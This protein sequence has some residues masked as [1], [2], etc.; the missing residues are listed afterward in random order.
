MTPGKVHSTMVALQAIADD[1][2][3]F[4]PGVIRAAADNA[5]ELLR[6]ARASYADAQMWRMGRTHGL[7]SDDAAQ[8]IS[9]AW[10]NAPEDCEPHAKCNGFMPGADPGRCLH[11]GIKV[12]AHQRRGGN[13]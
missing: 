5:L 7:I 12:E 6:E 1:P 10:G 11:C 3:S 13:G 2:R 8:K 4:A 9:F